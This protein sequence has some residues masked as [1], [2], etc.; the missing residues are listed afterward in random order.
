MFFHIFVV[1]GKPG[2]LAMTKGLIRD[3]CFQIWQPGQNGVG[4]RWR[5]CLEML[6]LQV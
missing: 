6:K 5:G 3:I 4:N 2:S 1:N